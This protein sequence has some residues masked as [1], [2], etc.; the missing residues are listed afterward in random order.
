VNPNKNK[1]TPSII[2]S[3]TTTLNIGPTDHTP[4]IRFDPAIETLF[5]EGKCF[6]DNSA[7]FFA[8]VHDTVE[9]FLK[10]RPSSLTFD[11]RLDYFNTSSSKALLDILRLAEKSIIADKV[12]VLWHYD[13]GDDDL[14]ESGED[15]ASLVDLKFNLVQEGAD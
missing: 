1:S 11:V 14:R 10:S 9:R 5:I 3:D 8:P 4:G 6:P 15:Y 7:M 13:N 12:Q 2:M